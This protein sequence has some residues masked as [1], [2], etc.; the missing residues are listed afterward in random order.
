MVFPKQI[1]FYGRKKASYFNSIQMRK[2]FR[3]ESSFETSFMLQQEFNDDVFAWAAQAQSFVFNM[4]GKNTRYTPD[5]IRKRKTSDGEVIEFIELKPN[6][7]AN[8]ELVYTKH[9][10]LSEK[11]LDRYNRPLTVLTEA[12]FYKPTKAD[13]LSR[14]YHYR[15]YD[16]SRYDLDLAFTHLTDI[17]CVGDLYEKCSL[18]NATPAFGPALIAQNK[19]MIDFEQP[20]SLDLPLEVNYG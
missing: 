18:F 9:Q 12:D 17:K 7:F 6:V 16:F 14:F 3:A 2:T 13:N 19:I 11:F 4:K 15:A 5:I 20:Y 10:Q 8:N 1:R